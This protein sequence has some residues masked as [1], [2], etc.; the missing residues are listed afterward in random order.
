[1]Q[2][3]Q[4]WIDTPCDGLTFSRAYRGNVNT[5]QMEELVLEKQD[6][7]W[8]LSIAVE[9]SVKTVHSTA[10]EGL[11]YSRVCASTK[12]CGGSS[13][14]LMFGMLFHF[15]CMKKEGTGSLN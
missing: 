7:V 15:G 10:C 3:I 5:T 14:N 12:M 9:L 2:G 1:V 8:D 11:V 4:K 6:T 13:Q